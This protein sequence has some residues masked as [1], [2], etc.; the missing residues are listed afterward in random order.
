MEHV[1]ADDTVGGERIEQDQEHGEE[2]AAAHGGEPDDEAAEEAQGH[3]RDL[4]GAVMRM[5]SWRE[6]STSMTTLTTSR[7]ATARSAPPMAR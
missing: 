4:A 7:I 6:R 2:G 1:G 5:F 3:G